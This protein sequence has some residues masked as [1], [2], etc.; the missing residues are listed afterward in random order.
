VEELNQL[1]ARQGGDWT[2]RGVIDILGQIYALS[3]DTKL[4][5][6]IMELVLLPQ[7][8]RICRE[9]YGYRVV[10]SPEQNYYPDLTFIDR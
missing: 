6:K 5:S 10:L 9:Q 3:A 8:L 1:L 7:L 4:I 2:I